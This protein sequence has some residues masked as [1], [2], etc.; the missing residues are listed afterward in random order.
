MSVTINSAIL[1]MLRKETEI[2]VINVSR[3]SPK[4]AVIFVRF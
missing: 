2:N 3:S 1:A 4:V